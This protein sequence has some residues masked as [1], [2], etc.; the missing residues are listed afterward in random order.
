MSSYVKAGCA[1]FK[2]KEDFIDHGVKPPSLVD[3]ET[4]FPSRDLL[5]HTTEPGV[6]ES[7]H[8]T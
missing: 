1:A 8:G 5:P 7:Q 3:M 4:E 6:L 2:T